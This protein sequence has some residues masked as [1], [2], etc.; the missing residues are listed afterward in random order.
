MNFIVL[1]KM[2]TAYFF[3][4]FTCDSVS[5]DYFHDVRRT[6]GNISCLFKCPKKGWHAPP[7]SKTLR[8]LLGN[9]RLE[10]KLNYWGASACFTWRQLSPVS[11]K[12]SSPFF[13]PTTAVNSQRRR[14]NTMWEVK[15]S[16]VGWPICW[17]SI[18]FSWILVFQSWMVTRKQ[19]LQ[20]NNVSCVKSRLDGS[21]RVVWMRRWDGPKQDTKA[22]YWL[23]L[24]SYC[25]SVI[26]K[27]IT[28]TWITVLGLRARRDA[29]TLEGHTRSKIA[30]KSIVNNRLVVWLLCE[31]EQDSV[32]HGRV[33]HFNP[34]PR[35]WSLVSHHQHMGSRIKRFSPP[36]T[37]GPW[38]RVSCQMWHLTHEIWFC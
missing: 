4:I 7:F 16:R 3:S 34:W 38:P 27:S 5:S 10:N 20:H 32:W 17:W 1:K 30:S 23:V 31:S 37:L 18:W 36:L 21:G 35:V 11:K 6:D 19:L 29:C 22:V 26:L 28:C 12:A 24:Y 33:M 14:K 8:Q 9:Q 15:N 13:L 2:K 25:S